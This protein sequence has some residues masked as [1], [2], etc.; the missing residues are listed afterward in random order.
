MLPLLG[1]FLV[2]K[3]ENQENFYTDLFKWRDPSLC[4]HDSNGLR[5]GVNT[6]RDYRDQEISTKSDM[7][8][9]SSKF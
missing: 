9:G 5:E 1:S 2:D 8:F 7:T 3:L 4:E 6:D